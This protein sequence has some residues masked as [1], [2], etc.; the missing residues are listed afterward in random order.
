MSDPALR[1]NLQHGRVFNQHI[2]KDMPQAFLFGVIDHTTHQQPAKSV[3]LEQRTYQDRELRRLF[4]EF[5]NQAHEPQ[6]VTCV[7]V[8]H[9]ESYFVP[10]IQLCQLIDFRG[11]ELG[12][13]PEKIEVAGPRR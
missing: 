8:K 6:H 12:N 5:V 9:D 11:G 4:F 7:F 3:T 10:V 2:A 13:T 1:G